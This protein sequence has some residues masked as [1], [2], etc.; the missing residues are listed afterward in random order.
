MRLVLFLLLEPHQVGTTANSYTCAIFRY[1][2]SHNSQ[3]V[4][5]NVVEISILVDNDRN[6]AKL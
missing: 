4:P 6:P 5:C 1:L 2:K 3:I